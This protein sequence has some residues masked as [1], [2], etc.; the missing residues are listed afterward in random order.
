MNVDANIQLEYTAWSRREK[1]TIACPEAQ[2]KITNLKTKQ[3]NSFERYSL[4]FF[5]PLKMLLW[6]RRWSNNRRFFLFPFPLR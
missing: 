6:L 4:F 5:Q 2:E 3:Q 1:T